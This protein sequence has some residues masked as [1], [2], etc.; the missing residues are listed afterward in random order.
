MLKGLWCFESLPGTSWKQYVGVVLGMRRV[1]K[2]RNFFL[3]KVEILLNGALLAIV[4]ECNKIIY[5][6]F[7]L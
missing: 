3:R 6:S 5:L 4:V 2:C 1:Y 7:D